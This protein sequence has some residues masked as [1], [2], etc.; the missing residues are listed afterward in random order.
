M[1]EGAA[2]GWSSCDWSFQYERIAAVVVAV[3]YDEE[4]YSVLLMVGRGWCGGGGGGGGWMTGWREARHDLAHHG[5][6]G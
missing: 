2:V 5:M 1:L 4:N 6:E 3:C